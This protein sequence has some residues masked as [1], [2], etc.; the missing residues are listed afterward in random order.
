M[1]G[2]EAAA[3]PTVSMSTSNHVTLYF[4]P[5]GTAYARIRLDSD[6]TEDSNTVG[7]LS[8]LTDQARG[9]WLDSGDAGDVWVERT[10]NSGTLDNDDPGAGRLNLGTG[11]IYGVSHSTPPRGSTTANVTFDFYDAASG[12]SLL[13]TNTIDLT[14]EVNNA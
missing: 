14:A 8:T 1:F 6:G 7:N 9:T 2:G 13:Q 10:I 11:R 5:N 12:G 4:S 3:P